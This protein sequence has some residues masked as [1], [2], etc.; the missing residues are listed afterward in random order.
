MESEV[1]PIDSFL[2]NQR[3]ELSIKLA[4]ERKS[5]ELLFLSQVPGSVSLCFYLNHSFPT[6]APKCCQQQEREF[7]NWDHSKEGNN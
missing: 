4:N 5:E 6:D 2:I 1:N 3:A 7:F